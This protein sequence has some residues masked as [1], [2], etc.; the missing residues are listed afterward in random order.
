MAA[1]L[2]PLGDAVEELDEID[3]AIREN[4]TKAPVVGYIDDPAN[5]EDLEQ[6]RPDTRYKDYTAWKALAGVTYDRILGNRLA[7]P[8]LTVKWL[9]EIVETGEKVVYQILFGQ[10]TS[11]AEQCHLLLAN[12]SFVLDPKDLSKAVEL[13]IVKAI[14]HPGCVNRCAYSPKEPHLVTTMTES[15]E[16]LLFDLRDHPDETPDG[17][18]N[19]KASLRHH[20]E[21]GYAMEWNPTVTGSLA[22][23]ADDAVV[24][25]WDANAAPKR[26]SEGVLKLSPLRA[27]G[28][29]EKGHSAGVNDL[30]WSTAD[31]NLLATVSNDKHLLVWDTRAFSVA[32]RVE[33]AH[34]TDVNSVAMARLSAHFLGTGGEDGSLKVWDLRKLGAPVWAPETHHEK[35]VLSIAWHPSNA[36]LLATSSADTDVFLWSLNEQEEFFAHT[37]HVGPVIE[38]AWCEDP[39]GDGITLVSV[40]DE[41]N[42][43]FVWEPNDEALEDE[44]EE[45]DADDA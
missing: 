41:D 32:Q 1:P 34:A 31:S 7:Y 10:N 44:D 22:T 33:K 20:T 12:I 8:S 27:L 25:L 14:N 21:E 35:S 16:A 11:G 5:V 36:D 2:E 17:D 24:C 43:M 40:S 15:G 37:G 9:P 26:D 19:V 45:G 6:E 23:G 39:A 28:A 29:A 13:E 42:M 30:S 4:G 38:V 3:Q 18:L